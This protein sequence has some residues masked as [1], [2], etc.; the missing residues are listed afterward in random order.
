MRN[1]YIRA[2][3]PLLA[4][5]LS[6]AGWFLLIISAFSGGLFS[7]PPIWAIIPF[8]LGLSFIVVLPAAAAFSLIQK[9]WRSIILG[10]VTVIIG[11]SVTLILGLIWGR[12]N[13]LLPFCFTCYESMKSMLPASVMVAFLTASVMVAFLIA[14]S[15]RL[16]NVSGYI[17]LIASLALTFFVSFIVE[18]ALYNVI[19]E[20]RS[21]A[22][23][24]FLYLL[25]TLAFSLSVL[26]NMFVVEH[27]NIKKVLLF[28]AFII[29][30]CIVFV[31]IPGRFLLSIF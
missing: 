16:N 18:K 12:L 15:G 21:L 24:V 20:G 22:Q 5:V 17:A 3:L 25:P 1:W 10:I 26:F 6:T 19:V 13:E 29:S 7:S 2:A 23:A 4:G 14:T 30:T 8:L 28:T 31:L 27:L 9:L 11:Y